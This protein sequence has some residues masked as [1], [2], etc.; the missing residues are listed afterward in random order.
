MAD[1]GSTAN[2][3]SQQSFSG[4]R[5]YGFSLGA[6]PG[7]G[8]LIAGHARLSVS[9]ASSPGC[10]LL[11]Y[12]D[13]G[14]TPVG[15]ALLATSDETIISNTTEALKD[16]TFSGANQISLVSG[17]TYWLFVGFDDPGTPNFQISRANNVGVVHFRGIV[18][19]TFDDPFVSDGTSNGPLDAYLEYT[20]AAGGATGLLGAL[21]LSKL[22]I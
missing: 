14:G 21:L 8:T 18:Y 7:N 12:A 17:T 5:M 9:G 22:D 13:N 1:Y 3:T 20:P 16:F 6:A 15:G 4:D 19:P 11:V 10:K 2:N